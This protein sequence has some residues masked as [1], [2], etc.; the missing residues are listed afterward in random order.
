MLV[1]L[2]NIDGSYGEIRA[3]RDLTFTLSP[4]ESL[5]LV[6]RNGAGKTTAL[7]LIAGM[8]RPSRGEVIF[9]GEDVTSLYP[10]DRIRR[11]IVLVPE[12]RGIFPALTVDD[13]LRAG[14]YWQRPS[15]TVLEERRE[16]VFTLLPNLSRLRRQPAGSLSGGEQQMVAIGRALMGDPRLV[17]LDEPSLGLAPLAVISLYETLG[18]LLEAGQ[19]LILVEQY[20]G[21]ALELCQRVI[22]LD[23]G[24]S[25]V[26]GPSAEVASSSKLQDMYMAK[27][28]ELPC[29]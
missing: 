5:A 16:R 23:K 27:D 15:R 22:G 11:G 13:N 1:E 26:S 3:V 7:K 28:L 24:R 9:D 6:G 18:A 20:V 10:E 12:G 4:G 21:L 25:I 29:P 19:S 17:L 8:M 2:R 14:A